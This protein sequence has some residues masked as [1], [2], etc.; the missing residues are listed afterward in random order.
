MWPSEVRDL[1]E[2]VK[3]LGKGGF[4]DVWLGRPVMQEQSM[5]IVEG[6]PKGNNCVGEV[7]IKKVDTST[8]VGK[9]YAD[10]EIKILQKLDHPNIV[11]L[12]TVFKLADNEDV[13]PCSYIALSYAKGPTL[14]KILNVG[15]AVGVPLARQLSQEL[16]SAVAYM[17]NHAVIHRDLKPDNV[18]IT[19]ST[20]YD[21]AIW[22]DDS[23]GEKAVK[24]KKW[25][26]IL[27]DF[28]FVRAL[29]PDDVGEHIALAKLVHNNDI[30]DRQTAEELAEFD[31]DHN[32][33][34]NQPI[35]MQS[36]NNSERGRSR[37]NSMNKSISHKK[38][39]DL[40]ALG[41]R[42][43]AAPEIL[44]G[45]HSKLMKSNSGRGQRKAQAKQRSL[46]EF[47]SNYGMDA[48]A[49]SLG[50]TLRY[51][52]TGVPPGNDV[53]E[54]IAFKNNIFVNIL[55]SL[56]SCF[57]SKKSKSRLKRDMKYR[58]SEQCPKEATLLVRGLTHWDPAKR[59]TVRAAQFYPWITGSEEMTEDQKQRMKKKVVF[60]D[61][62]L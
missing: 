11:K 57:G 60:L 34:M 35:E 42:N 36:K 47:V 49:Y 29:Q 17:H 14:E 20:L 24:E 16:I 59:T 32:E 52:L 1:Y 41:N 46:A 9:G 25:H 45:V 22:D 54:Y 62:E 26:V 33:Y 48:D 4:G 51:A 55:K 12:V 6:T 23:L 61:I 3:P 28:G 31:V 58:K 21:D 27:V 8:D 2:P 56:G 40:S 50:A 5:K 44:K 43:Y 38:V 15:G 30:N 7:A 39:R 19:G 53:N 13:N 18:I 10:R 37:D